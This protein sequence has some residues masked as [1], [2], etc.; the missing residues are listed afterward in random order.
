MTAVYGMTASILWRRLDTP[1]HDACRL[2]EAAGGWRLD[3]AALFLHNGHVARLSYEVTCDRLWRTERGTVRGWLGEREIDHRIEHT[4]EGTWWIG[5]RSVP[6]VGDCLDLDLG[7]TPSTN[8]LSVRRC[9][10]A[11]G[12]ATDV[13]VA[14]LDVESGTLERLEQRYERRSEQTYWYESPRFDYRALLEVDAVGFVRLYPEL[15][16][17]ERERQTP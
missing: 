9:A 12:T 17:A 6:D 3:G 1:G 16:E 14:W 11:V 7:F 4:A 2:V 15:W 5:A 10:L 13:P 8:L